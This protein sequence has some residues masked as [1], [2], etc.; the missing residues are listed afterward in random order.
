MASHIIAPHEDTLLQEALAQV[1]ALKESAGEF[2]NMHQSAI[3][4]GWF[5]DEGNAIGAGMWGGGF[6]FRTACAMAFTHPSATTCVF[7]TES[8]R[9]LVVAHSRAF[10]TLNPYWKSVRNARIS[11]NVGTGHVYSITPRRPDKPLN[12]TT[13]YDCLRELEIFRKVNKWRRR[14]GEK[15]TRLDRDGEFFLRL[16]DD[17]DDGILRC[18]FVEPLQIANPTGKDEA[19]GAWFGI[20]FDDTNYEEPICYYVQPMNFNGSQI[21]AEQM[22]AWEEGVDADHMQHRTANVDISSPRG[23]PTTYDLA[24]RLEQAKTT[25]IGMGKMVDARAR[26]GIIA[27]HVNATVKTVQRLALRNLGPAATK[28][29][30]SLRTVFESPYGGLW[31]TND[32]TEYELPSPNLETDKIVHSIKADV[33]SVAAAVGFADFVLNADGSS[34]H[35]NSLVK[36]GPMD[37]SV[38][39]S[40]QDLIDD[41]IEVMERH[42]QLAAE[43]GRIH[44]ATADNVLELAAISVQPPTI[45]AR[46]RIQEAQ[47]DEIYNRIG[48]ESKETIGEKAG[49]DPDV[50]QARLKKNPTLIQ[51]QTELN[52]QLAKAGLKAAGGAGGALDNKRSHQPPTTA[53]AAGRGVP[54]GEEVGPS[55]HTTNRAEES[56]DALRTQWQDDPTPENQRALI[57][58][59]DRLRVE[60]GEELIESVEDVVLVEACDESHIIDGLPD[61]RQADHFSCGA[62]GSDCIGRHF[63]IGPQTLDGWKKALGTNDKTSTDPYAIVAYFTKLGAR[64][65]AKTHMTVSQLAAAIKNNSP[66]LVCVQDYMDVKEKEGFAMGHYL[67]V[68]GVIGQKPNRFIICQDSSAENAAHVPGGDVPPAEADN[69]GSIADLGRIMVPEKRWL[70]C[71][72]DETSSGVKLIRFGIV[73]SAPPKGGT[74][75]EPDTGSGS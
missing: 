47:A 14:Q 46:N 71:W 11:Y 52:M 49:F 38:G 21:S 17:N 19:H 41:D 53:Q 2:M 6:D 69:T 34:S 50:E 73:V 64:V 24:P 72:H 25:L 48:V 70:E 40:Q 26:I 9:R 31:R 60:R 33:Q 15:I 63:G 27:K 68:E 66:I 39:C 8:Q 23:V 44:G 29:R 4:Q 20:Q 1:A 28:E 22:E 18:R 45:I 42:L 62:A 65:H 55:Q 61:I 57:E 43:H 13:R 12:E 16:F 54:A 3:E 56:L 59:E 51:K 74:V 32:Q 36:E 75:A 37:K 35:S 7:L 67:V 30:G 58:A 5:Y 10:C